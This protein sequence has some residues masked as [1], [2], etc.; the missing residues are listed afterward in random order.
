M[1]EP[2]LSIAMCTY[3]G[4]QY[5]QEQLD[6]IL[7]QS[8]VNLELIISDDCSSD[9][10]IRIIE[11][12]QEKDPRI[13]LYKN[14]KNLGFLKNFEKSISLCTGKYIALADQDDI[15]KTN[16]LELF[17]HE[18]NDNVLIYSDAI[19]IDKDS[20]ETGTQL[21]R[22]KS[23]LC[24]GRCNKAFFLN[25]FVSGNTM[26]FKQEIVQH[27]IPI[28][29]HMSY[30]D[31]WIGYVAST[32]GSIT[33][34]EDSMTYYRKYEGQVTHQ[35][36]V[37]PTNIFHRLQ[38]KKNLRMKVANI[39]AKDCEAFLSLKIL[40]DEDTIKILE[41]LL[42]HYQNFEKIYF[43]YKLYKILHRYTEELFC[44]IRESKRPRRAFR[45]AVGMKLK[46]LS[47][48]IL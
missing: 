7:S 15:W 47:F 1:N 10:T 2:L 29:K 32:Y 43:N 34:T 12:Y 19:I 46:V 24:K 8:Y 45:T 28:P 25:N 14:E 40:K 13:K 42:K 48:F 26:M 27:I 18:I 37:I 16:K 17:F 36:D 21:V 22:P 3:N 35:G 5:L 39:R 4:E 44:S 20:N 11:R 33:Y 6:S 23:N 41:L 30:H 38:Y 9:S 31:I